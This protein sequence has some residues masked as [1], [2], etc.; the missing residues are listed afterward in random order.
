[1]PKPDFFLRPGNFMLTLWHRKGP[2]LGVLATTQQI[3][4]RIGE[5]NWGS[6]EDEFIL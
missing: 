1:M 6:F 3:R 5:M 4:R 2:F